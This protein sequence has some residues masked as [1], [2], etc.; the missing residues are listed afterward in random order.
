MTFD[1]EAYQQRVDILT[2]NAIEAAT[3]V[4]KLL[5]HPLSSIIDH[6]DD[7]ETARAALSKVKYNRRFIVKLAQVL[8]NALSTAD[9]LGRSH[10]VRKSEI[11]NPTV[12]GGFYVCPDCDGSGYRVL[13]PSA[14]PQSGTECIHCAG[15]GKLF[16][17]LAPADS[18]WIICQAAPVEV[19]FDL[20]PEEAAASIRRR[21]L[22]IAGVE[23]Q[24]LLDAVRESLARALETGESYADWANGIRGLFNTYGAPLAGG[25]M[26]LHT[27][28]RTN[29][30]GAYAAGQRA[31]M[32][33]M[34]DE[35]PLWRY[36]AIM[37][38]RVRPEH[39]QYNDMVFPTEEGPYPPIDYNCRCT[40][41]PLHQFQ[42]DREHIVPSDVPVD[43]DHVAFGD[44]WDDW[45]SSARADMPTDLGTIIDEESGP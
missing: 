9:A 42:I 41:I 27:I 44:S 32:R 26:H 6:S 11:L 29:L 36:S 43:P 40:A 18:E 23:N 19:N 21:A 4:Y 25:E 2:E 12:A 24:K 14:L 37:D 13:A 10:V 28:F 22:T 31:Q 8:D 38:S 5:I 35:F 30:F 1:D 15:T 34:Q 45:S 39:A 7:L 33:N 16:T 17:G 3:P 20:T